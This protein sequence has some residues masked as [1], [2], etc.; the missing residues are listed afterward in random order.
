[1]IFTCTQEKNRK[2]EMKKHLLLALSFS[3]LLLNLPTTH[4][5]ACDKRVA[6]TSNFP[7]CNA[8]LSYADR[9]KDLVL[10]LTLQE[11]VQQL[12]NKATGVSRL[13]VSGYEWWSEALHG[14]SNTGPGVRFNSTVPGATSFPAVILSAATFNPSLWYE[15][16]QVVSTE[17]RAM[18]NVGLAGLTYWSPNVNVFRDPRWG[19]GQETPGED[20]LVVGKYA[21]NYVRGLQ[22][23]GQK[24]NLITSDGL[25]VSSC[26]KHYTAYD[27][28]NWKGIDRFHFDAKVT[29]QDM[30]DTYQPPFKSCVLDGHVSSVMCSYNRVNGVPTC[31]DPDLLKGVVRGQWGL[32]GYIVSD[33]DSIEVFYNSIHYTATPE[34]AVALALKA[35]LEMNCG[36]Y[37]GKYTENAIKLNKVEESVVDQALINNYIVLMRLGFFDGDPTQLPFGKLGPTDVC[38]DDHQKLALEAAKQGIVLLDNHGTLPLSPNTIKTL[39]VIGPNAN[40]TRVMISNYAGV[41]CKYTSPLQG[42]QKYVS[43]VTYQPGCANVGCSNGSLIDSAAKAAATA[44]AVVVI[45]GLDQSIEAEGLDRVNLTLPGLQEK[46]VMEVANA[47]TAPVVLVVMSAGPIDVSFARNQ[48]KIGAILWVGYPGQAGGDAIAQVIFGDYNP[49]GRSPF[50]WYPQEYVDQVPMTDMNMRA[51]TSRNFPGRTYRFYTGKTVYEFGHGLSYSIFSKFIKSAPSTIVVPLKTPI[52]N[53][54]DILF[55]ISTT[56]RHPNA[57]AIEVSSVNCQGL[58]FDV[59]ISVKNT[60]DRD[61][62]HVVL[63]FWKPPTSKRVNGTPN[64][65]LIGFERVEV[66]RGKVEM[67]KLGVDV[68]KDMSVADGEGKRKLVSG[69]HTLVLGSSSEHQVRHHLSLRLSGSEREGSSSM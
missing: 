27:V 46:L 14:V 33:C 3:V 41:P 31:A 56:G 32:D 68:C 67:V 38:T 19:R 37:L 20:P 63:L 12:V 66:K 53:Q 17:A 13:G 23:M 69:H 42:L 18:Y 5:Y 15:M 64:R 55:S 10:R 16:G 47:A 62:D 39:A 40:V 60:G 30:E 45:V 9:A 8:S 25:K 48:S 22:E 24:G 59:E 51:N 26:C 34:D 54:S 50:T 6:D 7:F 65:Q 57:Q 49:G 21:V 58:Q 43:S 1:M 52:S 2:K 36:D 29:L 4:Q 11:K 44:D 28:D 35:G 61:G